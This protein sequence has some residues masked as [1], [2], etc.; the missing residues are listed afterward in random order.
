MSTGLKNPKTC[1]KTQELVVKS[2]M[3]SDDTYIVPR[4][5]APFNFHVSTFSS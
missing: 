2:S 5:D 1:L 3:D 4:Q